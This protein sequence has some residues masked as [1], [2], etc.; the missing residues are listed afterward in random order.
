MPRTDQHVERSIVLDAP[1]EEVW[2]A[3]T[4]DDLLEEWLGD[5][6]TLDPCEGGAIEVSDGTDVRHGVVDHI[7]E[8]RRLSFRWW[9]E[10]EDARAV[11]L[12]VIALPDGRTRLRVVESREAPVV[13]PHLAALAAMMRCVAA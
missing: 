13:G 6:V 5:E 11:D 1:P 3:L 2:H 12:R 8:P 4:C 9:R 10:D 7:D